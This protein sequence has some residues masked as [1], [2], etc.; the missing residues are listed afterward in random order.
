[1]KIS[2]LLKLSVAV[3]IISGAF[4]FTGVTTVQTSPQVLVK[5]VATEE[6]IDIIT[7]KG[8]MVVYSK[9]QSVSGKAGSRIVVHSG[10]VDIGYGIYHLQADKVT[11]YEKSNKIIAEGN[12][13]FKKGNSQ[14]V[15]TRKLELNYKE[16]K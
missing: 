10:S 16:I 9:E 3:T 11:I 6:K 2:N 1:M 13:V 14:P 8:E 15:T 7:A 12:V 4:I 5:A